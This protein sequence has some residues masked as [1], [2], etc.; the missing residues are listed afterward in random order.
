MSLTS[1]EFLCFL[2]AAASVYRICPPRVRPAWMLIVSYL[3]Y[4][5]WSARGAALLAGMT[6]FA[7]ITGLAVEKP[8][9]RTGTLA[10]AAT[11]LLT[12]YLM[13]F[14]VALLLPQKGIAG[15]IMPLGV[16]YYSFKL[17]AYV[18][19]VYWG[20]MKASHHLVLFAAYVAF[21]PQ[22][23]AGPIQRPED[24]FNQS[25]F[26]PMPV[27][28]AVPR[29]AWG[30][31][32]KLFIADNL[33]PAVNYV[34]AHTGELHG[35]S[36][37]LGFYLFPLQ[38]YADFSGLTDIAIGTGRLFGV[39]GPE[40]FNRPFTAATISDYWR[41]WHMSLT[42][43][44]ADFV[45]LPLRMATRQWG[46][47][48]LAISITVNLVLIGL[49]HGLTLPYLVF[50]LLHA[51][52]LI[53]DVFV[54]PKRSRL[55]TFHLV[56]LA[57]VFFRAVHVSDALLLLMHLVQGFPDWAMLRTVL[58]ET[59]PRFL[60]LGLAGYALLEWAE[61]VRPDRWSWIQ[62]PAASSWERWALYSACAVFLLAGISLILHAGSGHSPFIYEIF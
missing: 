16:S 19:N 17:I 1:F 43:W 12:A 32:K 28:Q 51:G 52:F 13:A 38:L 35:A 11:T 34:F 61:R 10:I 41:R 5:S 27:S 26:T 53:L 2:T 3:F 8:T 14:K 46:R 49:W 29:I 22:I 55:L 23:V 7:Y 6:L 60:A 21:F 31:F 9:V 40:N 36:L 33:A 62:R 56:A 20:K 15:L 50:G 4:L 37:L 45:F 57:L 44:L 25:P 48:G 59:G 58:G 30:F 47:W 24:F 18:L 42:T 54:K 39:N